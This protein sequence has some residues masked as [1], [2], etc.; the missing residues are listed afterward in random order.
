M[1]REL[2]EILEHANRVKFN[3]RPLRPFIFALAPGK[4]V[5]HVCDHQNVVTVTAK[6]VL[7][8]VFSNFC[9]TRTFNWEFKGGVDRSVDHL[10]VMRSVSAP[11]DDTRWYSSIETTR[12]LPELLIV[13]E[14]SLPGIVS[15]EVLSSPPSVSNV[16]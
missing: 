1:V 15:N 9:S 8:N 13:K 5:G 4:C 16:L 10:N 3:L 12:R 6:T 11:A 2:L 14:P 7:N